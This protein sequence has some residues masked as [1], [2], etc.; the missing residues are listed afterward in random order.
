MGDIGALWGSMADTRNP[1]G[2]SYDPVIFSEIPSSNIEETH[3]AHCWALFGWQ[4][5]VSQR[6]TKEVREDVKQVL[7]WSELGCVIEDSKWI[8]T[9]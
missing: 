4:D 1:V 3:I 5:G 8:E 7:E 9:C 2:A 6:I